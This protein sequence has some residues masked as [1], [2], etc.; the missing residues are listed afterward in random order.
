MWTLG[1]CQTAQDACIRGHSS[2][3]ASNRVHE[4]QSRTA[5]TAGAHRYQERTCT[6]RVPFDGCHRV[7]LRCA[8][9]EMHLQPRFQYGSTC[10]QRL[11]D[12]APES[13]RAGTAW[14]GNLAAAT[15]AQWAAMG[16]IA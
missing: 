4:P 15:P 1:H 3:I 10:F 7:E 2:R 6:R 14:P 8:C 13:F 5:I 16:L 12:V 11:A 9:H